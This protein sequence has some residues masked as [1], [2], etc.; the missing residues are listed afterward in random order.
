MLVVDAL[1]ILTGASVLAF[2]A[3]CDVKWRRAPDAAW[4]LMALV[5]AVLLGVQAILQPGFFDVY[6]PALVTAG[7]VAVLA[8][9]GYATGLIAGGADAKALVSLSVL[10]PVPLD[11][12]WSLPL[13]SLLPLVVTA[14]ANGLLVGLA[15]P[16]ALAFVNI[17]RGD[18]DGMRT[19]LATRVALDRLEE[20]VVWPLEYV[21][22]DG[23]IVTA[24]MPGNVP[25]DAFDPDDLAAEGRKRIWVSPKIPFL[26][27]LTFGFA[28]AVILGDPLAALLRLL[29]V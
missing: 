10:A 29:L 5:G 8:M 21:G 9:A 26:V 15:V 4:V 2:A 25:L 6:L 17:A 14:V 23:E 13:E 20:R 1:R 22:T 24:T 3:A 11:A 19:F 27:P 7:V 18:I 12:A 28:V 16:L